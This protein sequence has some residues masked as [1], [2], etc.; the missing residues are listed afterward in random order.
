MKPA[1]PLL[2]LL[3]L[4]GCGLGPD[5]ERG[6]ADVAG[7][8]SLNSGLP[9]PNPLVTV[10]GCGGRAHPLTQG[11]SLG[12]YHLSLESTVGRHA[13]SLNVTGDGLPV[14]QVDTAIGF[15]PLGLH[16]IQIIDIHQASAP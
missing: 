9:Y 1:L 14:I 16:P 5:D 13:C 12:H 6:Y 4:T 11:D 2:T 8:V 15:A 7:D 3:S 10:E